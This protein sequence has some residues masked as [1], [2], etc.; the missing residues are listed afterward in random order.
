M[1]AQPKDSF[2]FISEPTLRS[3]LALYAQEVPNRCLLDADSKCPMLGFSLA[4]I[5]CIHGG[6]ITRQ[7]AKNSALSQLSPALNEHRQVSKKW[8]RGPSWGQVIVRDEGVYVQAPGRSREGAT[9][10]DQA[11]A[12]GFT[13]RDHK[14]GFQSQGRALPSRGDE[15]R[16]HPSR[17][18]WGPGDSQL[19]HCSLGAKGMP[20]RAN[21]KGNTSTGYC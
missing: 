19:D 3:N 8:T 15:V 14:A 1:H 21:L 7:G 4:T 12:D 17:G 20:R 2:L 16:T 18:G 13:G 10:S 11:A 6:A 9:H 5:H